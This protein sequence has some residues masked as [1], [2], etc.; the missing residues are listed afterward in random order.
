MNAALQ[1]LYVDLT[2]DDD[3]H[4]DGEDESTA[5][6]LGHFHCMQPFGHSY[7]CCT[8]GDIIPKPSPKFRWKFMGMIRGKPKVKVWTQNSA[9]SQ[10]TK[11]KFAL[12][13][14]IGAQCAYENTVYPLFSTQ[15][16][17]VF[18][19]FCKKPPQEWFVNKD[20]TRPKAMLQSCSSTGIPLLGVKKP[21]TDNCLKFVLDCLTGL[22]Y[23]DDSQ[24][25]SIDAMKCYDIYPPYEGRTLVSFSLVRAFDSL[26]AWG[27]GPNPGP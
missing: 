26:P 17:A 6:S 11:T 15:P 9:S 16:V 18:V 21:D 24:V 25:C 3:T 2:H 1:N 23:T 4:D 10:M 27:I 12:R 7:I 22:A 14:Q 20:R 8:V 13:D 5:L 19:C